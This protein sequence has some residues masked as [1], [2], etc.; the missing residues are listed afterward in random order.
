MQPLYSDEK[1]DE[2]EDNFHATVYQQV[3][4]ISIEKP[5]KKIQSVASIACRI[6]HTTTPNECLISPCNCKGSLAYVHLSCLER[7]LNQSSRSYC[8]LCMYQYNAVETKRYRLCEG[9]KLWMRHPRNRRHVRS[10][11][12]IA[13]ILTLVTTALIASCLMGMEYFVVE[14]NKLGL[15]RKWMKTAIYMFLFVV[16]LGYVVTIYLIIKDQFVPW[17][18]WWKNTVDIRL[19]L[20]S[21]VT[22]YN[23]IK[24]N[25]KAAASQI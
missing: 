4:R 3:S 7:W 12:L 1:F 15:Q 25:D 21:H 22:A 20:P 23:A 9:L 10:D 19:L 16:A 13:V 11:L 18:R 24:V 17:F 14:A 5:P 2:G 8:E 6:C